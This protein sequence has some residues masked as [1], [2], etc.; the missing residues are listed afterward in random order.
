VSWWALLKSKI[1]NARYAMMATARTP[2][3]SSSAMGV[4]LLFIKSAM[5]FH[6]YLKV[7]GFAESAKTLVEVFR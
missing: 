6:S 2:T 1:A 4:T 3:R 7:N 5:V